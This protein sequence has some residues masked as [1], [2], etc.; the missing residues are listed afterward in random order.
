ME[1][2]SASAIEARLKTR[3]LGRAVHCHGE[4]G[5][6]N[7]EAVRL[8][9]EGAPDGTLVI[10]DSQS[11]G[12]GRLGRQWFAPPGS[13]LLFSLLLRPP[14]APALAQRA[15]MVCT[16]G[17]MRAIVA[18]SGVP[19][20]IKWPNDLVVAGRKLGGVLTELGLTPDGALDYV[21]VGIGL[22]VNLNLADL[23]EVLTP[24]TSLLAECGQ[25]VSRLDLLARL[26]LETEALYLRLCGGWSPHEE[27]R[28]ALATIGQQVQVGTTEA[29]IVGTAMDVT[30]TGAL[31][32]EE[33]SGA[34]HVVLA[35]D[36][37]LRGHRLGQ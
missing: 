14:L 37:T 34:R 8:A 19:A 21:V 33:Q 25:P 9:R 18:L 20:R 3:V 16:L 12:K 35:G 26:L 15:T 29:V 28:A 6:T 24:P 17:A 2:L 30:D 1:T 4:I 11:A 36:V 22:N 10:A 23:P 31:V 13:A 7:I 5:S 32:V 27:W